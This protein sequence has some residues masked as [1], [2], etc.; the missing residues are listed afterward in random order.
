MPFSVAHDAVAV[1]DG[2]SFIKDAPAWDDP[3]TMFSLTEYGMLRS[4]PS[5]SGESGETGAA[6]GHSSLYNSR[7]VQQRSCASARGRRPPSYCEDF[8]RTATGFTFDRDRLAS[9]RFFCKPFLIAFSRS[10]LVIPQRTVSGC[11]GFFR[12]KGNASAL[13]GRSSPKRRTDA[14]I[15]RMAVYRRNAAVSIGRPFEKYWRES[16]M[17]SF[18]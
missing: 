7:F 16:L 3:V 17:R 4:S 6:S 5:S 12:L 8:A 1:L 15:R 2:S 18:P 10:C 13:S 14:I 11:F 9:A